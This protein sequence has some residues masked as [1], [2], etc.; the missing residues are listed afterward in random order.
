ML[1]CCKKQSHIP[2]ITLFPHVSST[3]C[4]LGPLEW[5]M[6]VPGWCWVRSRHQT[7]SLHGPFGGFS[8]FPICE[9]GQI[10]WG[11]FLF[12]MNASFGG[13]GGSAMR[14]TS[15]VHRNFC[16]SQKKSFYKLFNRERREGRETALK[17]NSAVLPRLVVLPA[18]DAL[19]HPFPCSKHRLT[20]QC[21]EPTGCR[22]SDLMCNWEFINHLNHWNCFFFGQISFLRTPAITFSVLWIFSFGEVIESE[23]NTWHSLN[24]HTNFTGAR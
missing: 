3:A 24:L 10:V 19:L 14:E 16:G 23:K 13:F 7:H 9:D 20:K 6:L 4:P 15:G 12:A 21:K 17:F 11:R 18:S 1:S 8:S 22:K 2:F 5:T